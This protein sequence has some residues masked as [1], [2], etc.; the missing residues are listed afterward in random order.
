MGLQR[1]HLVERAAW[2]H[3]K[4][5]KPKL[6]LDK[7]YNLFQ[8]W[9]YLIF[10]LR[11]KIE[12]FKLLLNPLTPFAIIKLVLVILCCSLFECHYMYLDPLGNQRNTWLID[13]IYVYVIIVLWLPLINILKLFS[14]VATGWPFKNRSSW[15]LS[16]YIP[17]WNLTFYSIVIVFQLLRIIRVKSGSMSAILNLT[18]LKIFTVPVLPI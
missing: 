12:D 9:P 16:W 3:Q 11:H 17:T 1:S 4:H 15:N 8:T 14:K 5:W 2:T 13:F 7:T 18:K 10:R 6:F